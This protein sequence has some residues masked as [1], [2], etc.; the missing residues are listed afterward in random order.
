VFENRVLRKIIRLKKEEITGGLRKL[1]TEGLHNLHS[2]PDIITNIK[3]TRMKLLRHVTCMKEVHTGFYSDTLNG[4][5][6]IQT[7][8]G[9][10]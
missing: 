7:S 8:G 5:P 9:L 6:R 2:S 10:E 3:S 1:H 4:R